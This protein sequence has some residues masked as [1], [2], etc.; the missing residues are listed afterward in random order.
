MDPYIVQDMRV[1]AFKEREILTAKGKLDLARKR[2]PGLGPL[3]SRAA[4]QLLE[5]DFAK[6]RREEMANLR[7]LMEIDGTMVPRDVKR[8]TDE[9]MMRRSEFSSPL[10][11]QK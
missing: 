1:P 2:Y 9:A 10:R 4:M 3:S 7:R 6:E 5:Q 11:S 8:M